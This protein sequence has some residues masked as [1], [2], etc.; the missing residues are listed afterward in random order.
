MTKKMIRVVCIGLA[1]YAVLVAIVSIRLYTSGTTNVWACILLG[2]AMVLVGGIIVWM[3]IMI[4]LDDLAHEVRI[5]GG[6]KI[7]HRLKI[8]SVTLL[9]LKLVEV[10]TEAESK[11][12]KSA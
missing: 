2:G 8:G 10:F 12:L 7:T 1:L 11:A 5:Y 3:G 4:S 9:R 6:R